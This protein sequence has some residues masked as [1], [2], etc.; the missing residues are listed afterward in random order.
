MFH[1]SL[2]FKRGLILLKLPAVNANI[3]SN[4]KGLEPTTTF[5]RKRKL[6]HLA[7]L[8]LDCGFTL[9]CLRDGIRTYSR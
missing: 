6:N 3:K 5:F 4:A 2:S 1:I 8:I 7:K 9:K